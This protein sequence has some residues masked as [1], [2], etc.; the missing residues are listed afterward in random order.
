MKDGRYIR[1]RMDRV[2][3]DRFEFVSNL[4][5]KEGIP[6]QKL[7]SLD[8]GCRNMELQKVLGIKDYVGVDFHSSIKE[9]TN[10]VSQDL[11]EPLPFKNKEFEIVYALDILEHLNNF[12]GC[13][14]EIRRVAAHYVLI[15]LPNMY[16]YAYRLKYLL[17]RPLNAKYYLP[18]NFILDRHRWIFTFNEAKALISQEFNMCAEITVWGHRLPYRQRSLRLLDCLVS[19]PGLGI[20]TIFFL[21]KI[22]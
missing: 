11:E 20:Y 4:L 2:Y 13:L 9:M 18:H 22:V 14:S 3:M 21:I 1:I 8:L 16:H 6:Y 12:H 19:S 5:R 7:Y 15:G 17:G 10:G